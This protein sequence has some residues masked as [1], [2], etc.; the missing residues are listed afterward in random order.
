MTDKKTD[1]KKPKGDPINKCIKAMMRLGILQPHFMLTHSKLRDKY[2]VVQGD[3]AK[4][5]TTMAVSKTGRIYLNEDFVNKISIEELGG[6]ICHEILHLVYLH[7]IRNNR[8]D[9]WLWNVATDMCI[10]QALK[11][12]GIQLPS[13]CLYPPPG[14]NDELHAEPLYEWLVKNP[15]QQ[16]KKPS[17]IQVGAGCSIGEDGEITG[18][19]TV[20]GKEVDVKDL[21][22]QFS[23]IDL[24][25]MAA[26]LRAAARQCGRGTSAVA[27]LLTP[28]QGKVPWKKVIRHGFQLVHAKP[29]RDFQT[30]ARRNRRSPSYGPQFPGWRGYEPSICI[31]IDVSGSMDREWVNEIVNES[32]HL[33]KEF[34]GTRVF[35]V[36]HTSQVVYAEWINRHTDHHKF[37]AAVS[38]TGGTDPNPA[39]ARIAEEKESFDCMIHMTDTEFG[40]W[41]KVPAKKLIV[42]VY[43]NHIM[44][45]PPKGATVMMMDRDEY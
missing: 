31:C 36:S 44:S 40:P 26:E 42:G 6:V 45:Q 21:K 7:H 38:F 27:A 28:K 13:S 14:Y 4:Q 29:G 20:D 15:Q 1:E 2:V 9:P 41:P 34:A 5:M 18:K 3:A 12:D 11:T 33:M 16:P 25:K 10:N 19:V 17:V 35:L 24:K 37:E 23:D 30:Y 39:Y 32:V 43:G 8:R 22:D